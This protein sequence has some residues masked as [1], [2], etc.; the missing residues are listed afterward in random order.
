MSR[1]VRIAHVLVV[2]LVSTALTTKARSGASDSTAQSASFTIYTGNKCA[3]PYYVDNAGAEACVIKS[4]VSASSVTLT[5]GAYD[6]NKDGF[7]ALN[8]SYFYQLVNNNWVQSYHWNFYNS[9]GRGTT[10]LQAPVKITK[11]TGST[12][13]KFV[14]MAC[15]YDSPT[16]VRKSC[17]SKTWVQN[18]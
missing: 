9:S 1:N 6:Y 7:S 11:R 14:I 5:A 10:K 4:N 16:K 2:L 12:K 15:T 17:G 13:A 8:E 3:G 18:W